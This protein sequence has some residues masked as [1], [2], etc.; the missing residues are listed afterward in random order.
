MQNQKVIEQLGYS[1]KEAKVYLASL[2]LGEAHIS[3]IADKVKMPRSSVQFIVDRL[4]DDGLMNFYVM[5]RYKYW[6]AEKPEQLLEN[7]QKREQIILDALPQLAELRKKAR[8]RKRYDKQYLKSV[9]M[10]S[11]LADATSIAVLI[12]NKDA[13]I[14]YVNTVWEKQLGY[15]FEEVYRKNPRLLKSEKTS[16]NVYEEMWK[17]LNAGKMFQSNKIINKRKDG[18][19][20]KLMTTIFP[21]QHGS[22]TFFIQILDDISG[23]K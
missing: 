20:F 22:R 7:F 6:V 9:E 17:A 11:A 19:F 2:S 18:T 5:R 15:T 1:T 16:P 13:E 23:Q 3:D 10:F 4:H 12:T 21:V 14:E 8:K